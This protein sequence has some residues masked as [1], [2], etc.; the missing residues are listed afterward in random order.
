MRSRVRDALKELDAAVVEDLSSRTNVWTEDEAEDRAWRKV[1][2][3]LE[4][5]LAIDGEARLQ[6]FREYQVGSQMESR[7]RTFDP[8]GNEIRALSFIPSDP[9]RSIPLHLDRPMD[10]QTDHLR[11]H[12]PVSESPSTITPHLA[13]LLRS[14]G[15]LYHLLSSHPDILQLVLHLPSESPPSSFEQAPGLDR[16]AAV[17]DAPGWLSLLSRRSASVPPQQVQRKPAHPTLK[18]PKETYTRVWIRLV[19]APD[20][21]EPLR[22]SESVNRG[23]L[24]SLTSTLRSMSISPSRRMTEA[25]GGTGRSH[26]RLRYVV[27]AD[28]TYVPDA[29]SDAAH[30][31]LSVTT[32]DPRAI[33]ILARILC[34]ETDPMRQRVQASSPITVLRSKTRVRTSLDLEDEEAHERPERGRPRSKEDPKL[35]EARVEA[36]SPKR[37]VSRGRRIWDGLFGGAAQDGRSVSVPPTIHEPIIIGDII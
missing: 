17:D 33:P 24:T 6:A 29:E 21:P 36:V 31:C 30:G 14:H 3:R 13:Y 25:P 2:S 26:S 10:E 12:F 37:E 11:L 8:G 23:G 4:L 18:K 35:L 16:P 7:L 9:I 28:S 1:R 5:F 20:K 22:R 32:T 27:Q 19:R 15:V 34:S